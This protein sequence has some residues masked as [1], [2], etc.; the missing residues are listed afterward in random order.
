VVYRGDN[1][2]NAN[3]GVSF[4]SASID[5]SYA[6]TDVDSRLAFRGQIVKALSVAAFKALS[7]AA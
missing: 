4:A 1:N 3:G 6:Y 2:A 5:A 7:E